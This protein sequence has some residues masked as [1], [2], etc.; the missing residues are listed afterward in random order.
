MHVIIYM[1]ER[2]FL[3]IFREGERER[4]SQ[5]LFLTITLVE[6]YGYWVSRISIYHVI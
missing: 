5:T 2:Y 6:S 4:G 3:Y 1:R